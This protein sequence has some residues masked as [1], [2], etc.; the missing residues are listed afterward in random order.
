[1][2]CGVRGPHFIFYARHLIFARGETLKHKSPVLLPSLFVA[3]LMLTACSVSTSATDQPLVSTEVLPTAI[4]ISQSSET[5]ITPLWD[6]AESVCEGESLYLWREAGTF[7]W[8]FSYPGYDE[9]STLTQGAAVYS[10][11]GD[12]VC[13][14]LSVGL[15]EIMKDVPVEGAKAQWSGSCQIT[16]LGSTRTIVQGIT[17]T[18]S[19]WEQKTT[20][21]GTFRALRVKSLN[22]YAVGTEPGIV[23]VNDWYVCGYGRVYS[24]SV[25]PKTDTKYVDELLSFTPQTT[26]ESRVRY[27][28]TDIQLMNIPDPYRAQITD[29]ETAE[30]LRRWDAGIRVANLDRFERQRINGQWQIVYVGSEKPL[31]GS[32]VRLTSDPQQ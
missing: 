18:V 4:Y 26:N 17:T 7:T 11:P 15:G 10:V 20:R 12:E 25:D 14:W 24:E 22:Q 13:G 5:L 27:I 32:D 2:P 21:L 6:H 29:E 23:E 28:L 19:G 8:R 9:I 30:A 16:A 31:T 1:M 3:V